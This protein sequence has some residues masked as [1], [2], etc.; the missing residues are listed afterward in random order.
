MRAVWFMRGPQPRGGTS[1]V[2]VRVQP[3]A[4]GRPSVGVIEEYLGGAGGQWRAA[5]WMAAFNATQAMGSTLAAH[6]VLVKA[7]GHIDGPSA[8][9]L[10]T[11]T[12]M[13]VVGGV[14]VR[15]DTTM[16]GT[17]NPDGTAGPVGGIPLKMEGASKAGIKRFGYPIGQRMGTY[18]G[19]RVS[20]LD[21]G[22]TLGLEVR[23]IRDLGDAFE[24]LTGVAPRELEM[25]DE[26]EMEL[27]RD[28]HGI[29]RARLM[30]LSGRIAQ[31]VPR[32][33]ARVQ[34]LSDANRQRV[35][36]LWNTATSNHAA[37]KRYEAGDQVVAAAHHFALASYA[38]RTLQHLIT[39]LGYWESFDLNGMRR[40]VD[41]VRAATTR[42]TALQTELRVRARSQ[43]V[44]GWV[45]G[46][47]GFSTLV[48][49]L[50]YGELGK[51]QYQ[52]AHK[53]LTGLASGQVTDGP[54]VREQLLQQ[55]LLSVVYFTTVE[56]VLDMERYSFVPRE[57]GA[58]RIGDLAVTG[59][60]ARAYGSA[61]GAALGYFDSLVTEVAARQHGL[62]VAE[63]QRRLAERELEYMTTRVAVKFAENVGALFPDASPAAQMLR[64]AAGGDAYLTAA[65]LINKFYSLRAERREDGTLVL[66][67]RKALGYQLDEAA[68]RARVAAATCKL[69]T[70]LVPTAAKVSYLQARALRDASD[71]DKLNALQSYWASTFW[72]NLAVSLAGR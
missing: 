71:D 51:Q 66:N 38:T 72:S 62:T 22:A 6:E 7:G 58:T 65:N 8:G 16:T 24:L 29:A 35:A 20:L 40:E 69:I 42:V 21:H 55:L 19:Q 17:V 37:A 47:S 48:T 14:P 3:S 10:L 32:I 25:L 44:G 11:A 49:A 28:L 12:M 5:T 50:A 46:V 4:T 34:G 70:G 57:E 18:R 15:T 9:M 30:D 61:A 63:A 39:L 2:S 43:T 13:A 67:N 64:M 60:L 36:A 33:E 45:N 52:L 54:T 1:T 41:A 68:R 53:T 59:Q 23:E 26:R 27:D 31:D 56:H